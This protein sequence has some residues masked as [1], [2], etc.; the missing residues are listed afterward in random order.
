MICGVHSSVN[1]LLSKSSVITCP[2]ISIGSCINSPFRILKP[3]VIIY[4]T[5]LTFDFGLH[6]PTV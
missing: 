2:K 4:F 6:I 1:I 3:K 5:E